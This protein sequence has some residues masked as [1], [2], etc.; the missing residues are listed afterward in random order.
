MTIPLPVIPNVFR[1]V[2]KWQFTPMTAINVIHVH[3]QAGPTTSTAVY[4]CI[5]SHVTANMWLAANS[6]AGVTEVQV[7]PLDG[8]SATST[9]TT[10]QPAKWSGGGTGDQ[11]P[12]VAAVVKFQTALRGRD[13]RGRLYM[14]FITESNTLAGSLVAP[15][16]SSM[17][18]AWNTF[19][20]ALLADGTT[21]LDFCVASYDRDHGGAGAHYTPIINCIAESVLGT[22]RRRQGRLRI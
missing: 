9:F 2:L 13:N 17:T 1:V 20:A 11:A 7:T 14:P 12:Q 22:Q 6:T 21:P 16:P 4:N 8:A 19:N 18:T 10:G 15:L 3:A 5:N